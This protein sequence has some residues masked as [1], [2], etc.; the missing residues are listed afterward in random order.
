VILNAG[1][2]GWDHDEGMRPF[3]EV[4]GLEAEVP[5]IIPDFRL[6]VRSWSRPGARLLA[7]RE[8][9][10]FGR[11]KGDAQGHQAKQHNRI[12]RSGQ[13]LTSCSRKLQILP[14]GPFERRARR[15]AD[16]RPVKR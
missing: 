10:G 6:N 15:K 2:I 14:P 9:H 3:P 8:R 11:P 5:G 4:L 16:K 1:A 7:N 13:D 12:S